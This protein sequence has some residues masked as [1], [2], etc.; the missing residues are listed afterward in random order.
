MV[1][2][3]LG[4]SELEDVALYT[5]EEKFTEL[6]KAGLKLTSLVRKEVN[7][8][9]DVSNFSNENISV[10]SFLTPS[11]KLFHAVYTSEDICDGGN[12]YGAVLDANLKSVAHIGDSDF[13]CID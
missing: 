12:S 5:I 13:Y 11:G 4:P 1:Y 8:V 7:K 2:Y 9:E 3:A 6:P 10:S